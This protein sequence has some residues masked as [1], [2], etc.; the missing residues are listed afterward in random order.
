MKAEYVDILKSTIKRLPEEAID[1]VKISQSNEFKLHAMSGLIDHKFNKVVDD[2]TEEELNEACKLTDSAL[3]PADIV[4][5]DTIP[6]KDI[7]IV[8][9]DEDEIT[10]CRVMIFDKD[11]R[12]PY[13][14]S[15]IR[16]E[17]GELS[18]LSIT[19][20]GA[21]VLYFSKTNYTTIPILITEHEGHEEFG[22]EANSAYMYNNGRI[23]TT[24]MSQFE[25]LGLLAACK[26]GMLLLT[27]WYSIEVSLL[28]PLIRYKTI[29]N[30]KVIPP[31]KTRSGKKKCGAPKI[32][33]FKTIY[34]EEEAL[35]QFFEDQK[36]EK[37]EI[38]RHCLMWYVTGHWRQ[39]KNGKKIFIQGYWK[40]EGR[41]SGIEAETRQRELILDE[42]DLPKER[43]PKPKTPARR[44]EVNPSYYENV[45]CECGKCSG[46]GMLTKTC[47]SCGKMVMYRKEE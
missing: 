30:Q 24:G 26:H 40:G 13:R 35:D 15:N 22:L 20:V 10:N 11:M 34:I 5:S 14:D 21:M 4:I 41:F 47:P 43:I 45:R 32:K 12:F 7:E 33:Y 18:V 28:N 27:L 17:K 19:C 8:Y 3:L 1:R 9:N 37:G 44:L 42:D 31:K 25:D 39:Y 23:I 38:H 46:T 6:I 16:S 36:N 2:M 29:E